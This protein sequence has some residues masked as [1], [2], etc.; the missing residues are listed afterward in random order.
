MKNGKRLDGYTLN[1][2]GEIVSRKATD[3]GNIKFSTFDNYLKEMGQKYSPGTTIRSNKY[4]DID[5]Q[6]LRGQQ[7]L[8]IPAS[9]QSLPN[10][11]DYINHA[12]NNY[13]IRIRFRPE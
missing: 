5:G 9:N 8:E 10:I 7:Y 11:Q 2:G 1:N 3:L 6:T 12:W 13:G 4:P